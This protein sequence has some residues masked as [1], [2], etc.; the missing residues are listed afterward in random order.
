MKNKLTIA[1]LLGLNLALV[2]FAEN[3]APAPDSA[4]TPAAAFFRNDLRCI[5]LPLISAIFRKTN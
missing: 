5:V 4:A 3:P 1:L 2:A